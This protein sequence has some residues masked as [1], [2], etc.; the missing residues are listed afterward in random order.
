MTSHDGHV[1]CHRSTTSTWL[2]IVVERGQLVVRTGPGPVGWWATGPDELR[3]VAAMLVEVADLAE[4]APAPAL[5]GQLSLLDGQLSLLEGT[6][7]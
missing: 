3:A 4:G 1:A 2:C 5:D 7:R 6:G